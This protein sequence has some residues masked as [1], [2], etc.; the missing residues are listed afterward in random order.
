MRKPQRGHC[1]LTG[2]ECAERLIIRAYLLQARELLRCGGEEA[3]ASI[4]LAGDLGA[5]RGVHGTGSGRMRGARQVRGGDPPQTGRSRHLA[6]VDGAG[7]AR[8]D[9]QFRC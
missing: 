1:L 9:S 5:D 3:L 7:R 6:A 2:N 8:G 4:V